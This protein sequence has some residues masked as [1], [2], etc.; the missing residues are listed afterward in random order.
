MKI[1]FLD[2]DGVLNYQ[3]SKSRCHG[4]LGIDNDKVKRLKRIVEATNAKIVLTS[5]WKI[6]WQRVN[7]ESQ[8]YSGSYLDKKLLMEGLYII[9]KTIDKGSDRGE[10]IH[11]WLNAYPVKE[12]VV[13]DDEIFS[14]YEA[15]GIMN[16]LV[17]T[18]FYAKDGGLQNKHV[19]T[20]I[21][22]L[23]SR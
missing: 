20:S 13:L 4:L 14:D 16:H 19:E 7:K 11:A 22:I 23:K 10:G 12:Y 8:H 17:Q 21:Q 3:Y 2:V 1:I 9:D 6:H 5:T 15:Y 18:D